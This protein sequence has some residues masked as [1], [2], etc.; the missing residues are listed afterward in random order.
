[1][2]SN[3]A[4]FILTHGRPDRLYTLDTLKKCGYTGK[5]YIIIDTEDK[6]ANEYIAKY[7]DKVRIFDKKEES[8]LF[9]TADTFDDRRAI[10][11]ARNVSFRIAKELKLDYFLELDDDYTNFRFR[12]EKDNVLRSIYC[13]HLDDV[14]EAM[15]DFLDA[16]PKIKTIAL[17]QTGDFIGGTDSNVFKQ[18]LARKCMNSFF[19]RV[20]RPF[21]FV[22]RVNEDVNTYTSLGN[23]GELLFTVAECSLDQL[24]TQSNLG[25]MTELYLDSGTYVKSFYSVMISPSCVKIGLMGQSNKRIHHKIYWNYCTPKIISEKYKKVIE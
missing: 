16:S 9:D 14:F 13:R 19:C 1:M 20:D 4:V 17:A 25:G 22:G 7:G 15:L 21:Q 11:Y 23:K 6:R 10:V 2:R 12:V 18:K 5:Y 3:F 8:K 24:A